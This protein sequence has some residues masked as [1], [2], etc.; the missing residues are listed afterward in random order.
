[1]S[2]NF[3]ITDTGPK[4]C[5]ASVRNCPVGG[6]HF[7]NKEEAQR[8]YEF[9]A[10]EKH[11]LF[12]GLKKKLNPYSKHVTEA[13]KRIESLESEMFARDLRQADGT[14]Y[15]QIFSDGF[16]PEELEKRFGEETHTREATISYMDLGENDARVLGL[17]YGGDY[18]AEEE[19]GM[20][21]ISASL[22]SEAYG[23]N[24]VVF[25]QNGDFS[26][27]AIRG[28]RTYGW[29][30]TDIS[31]NTS[32][33]NAEQKARSRYDSHSPWPLSKSMVY[34]RKSA[35]ELKAEFKEKAP[36]QTL[37]KNKAEYIKRLLEIDAGGSTPRTP[38]KGEFQTGNSLVIVTK[39]PLE[40]KLMSK[41]K[42]S[43]DAGALRVGSSNNPFSRGVMFY[44]DRDLSRDYKSAMIRNEEAEKSATAYIAGTQAELEKQGSVYSVS[45]DVPKG[46]TDI[47]E[48]RFW[49]NFTPRGR[50]QV[51]GW[52]KKEQLDRMAAGDFSDTEG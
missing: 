19:Y 16:T 9:T 21:H 7:G 22:A 38:A 52:F 27:L 34:G 30:N 35:V 1:M 26:V 10:G 43:H 13:D 4:P 17:S 44:D 11:G 18:K 6:A 49:L 32:V 47:R 23:P 29:D 3:H 12:G 48:S 28:E 20:A 24:D 14:L 5:S 33:V 31:K 40:A 42:A 51:S 39:D 50:K 25:Y 46:A 2:Q 8:A 41:L 45:P 37:P 36:G 15:D